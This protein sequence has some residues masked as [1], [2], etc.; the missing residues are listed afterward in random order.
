M[1][2]V[3]R[4]AFISALHL[5]H[6]SNMGRN[7]TAAAGHCEPCQTLVHSYIHTY[8]HSFNIFSAVKNT[9]ICRTKVGSCVSLTK[10]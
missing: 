8:I 3:D 2:G 6:S 4:L 5:T 10:S 7:R 9:Q 1:Y